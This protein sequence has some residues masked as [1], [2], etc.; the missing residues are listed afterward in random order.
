MTRGQPHRLS[1]TDHDRDSAELTYVYPVIS[2]RAGGVSVGIN[3]NTNNACNWRCVYCQVPGLIAGKAPATD[4][5]LLETELR[6]MFGEILQ[7]D[8][9]QSRVPE[10]AR[11][12]KDVAFSGNGEPTSSEQL[13]QCLSVVARV[14]TDVGLPSLPVVLIT[15][16][17]LV[18]KPRVQD[19]LRQLASMN[20]EVWFKLD[21]ATRDGL[22][23]I[24][25]VVADPERH[26]QRLQLAAGLCPTWVQTCVFRWDGEDPSAAERQ[27]YV[28]ALR[29]QLEAEVPLRGVLLYGIARP[30]HQPEAVRLSPV[31][32][33]YLKQLSD[34]LSALGLDVRTST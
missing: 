10:G 6:R 23:R 1:V 31:S 2:R 7:G 25:S 32:E 9:M 27:A 17:S 19:C 20:G 12:L 33:S 16:G 18:D 21:S 13:D 29:H 28:D 5:A 24:N 14:L 15:N 4:V 30:S 11:Q 3:L 34:E 8:F 26:L 22:K